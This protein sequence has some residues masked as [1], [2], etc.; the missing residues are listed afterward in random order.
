MVKNLNGSSL[1]ALY[2]N[3][4]TIK[5]RYFVV[6]VGDSFVV[7]DSDGIEKSARMSSSKFK[8]ARRNALT[9]LEADP[10]NPLRP[11]LQALIRYPATDI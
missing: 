1:A 6:K 7:A 3:G 11:E 10:G 8:T 9:S 5:D 4:G 2:L